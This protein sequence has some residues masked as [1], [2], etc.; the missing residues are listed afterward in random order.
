MDLAAVV[1]ERRRTL[2]LT[3]LD[4]ADMAGVSERFVRDVEAGKRSVRLDK[5]EALLAALGLR[6]TATVQR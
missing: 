3:Q 1:T 5:A 4:A 6:L 2:G